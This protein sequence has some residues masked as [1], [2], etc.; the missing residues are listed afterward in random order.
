MDAPSGA[1]R[2]TRRTG[3]LGSSGHGYGREIPRRWGL[4]PRVRCHD[5]A[6]PVLRLQRRRGLR[7]VVNGHSHFPSMQPL[8]WIDPQ[9]RSRGPHTGMSAP[10]DPAVR[11][12]HAVAAPRRRGRALPSSSVRRAR[13]RRRSH[14]VAPPIGDCADDAQLRWMGANDPS[15]RSWARMEIGV[16]PASLGVRR[17][18]ICVGHLSSGRQKAADLVDRGALSASCAP[19]PGSARRLLPT[20][21]G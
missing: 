11:S 4:L 1:P 18:V 5:G 13:R 6:R 19:P 16:V 14:H 9:R 10:A 15:R 12:A 17:W 3:S 20:A 7:Y 8:G 21:R 2:A